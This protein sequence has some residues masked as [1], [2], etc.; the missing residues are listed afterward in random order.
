MNTTE[1][2]RETRTRRR[3]HNAILASAVS[4]LSQ[5]P[6]ASLAEIADAAGVA[7]STLHRYFP[8]REDLLSTLRAHSQER[9][10]AAT[11]RA[12]PDE[13]SAL[14][15]LVRL[16]H[17]YFDL[18]ETL[19]WMYME[20]LHDNDGPNTIEEQLDPTLTRLI[21]RG[22]HDGSIDP[23]IPNSWIQQL[24]WAVLYS[25]W[26]FIRMGGSKHEALQLTLES[27]RRMTSPPKTTQ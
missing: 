27:V 12:R 22:Y 14:D 2:P 13:G 17:E 24:L 16:C 26:E 21:E 1:E 18:W 19:T 15:A 8:E 7:R 10:D 23:M 9:L 25:G 5:H 6:T 4:V 11:A 20:S 3:T